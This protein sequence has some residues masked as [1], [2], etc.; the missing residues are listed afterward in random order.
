MRVEARSI[1]RRR[2]SFIGT[3]LASRVPSPAHPP[4][5]R[6]QSGHVRSVARALRATIVT[7]SSAPG[8]TTG[9]RRLHP[10][11]P[12]SSPRRVA[13]ALRRDVRSCSTSRVQRMGFRPTRRARADLLALRDATAGRVGQKRRWR[14]VDERRSGPST[15]PAARCRDRLSSAALRASGPAQDHRRQAVADR[16]VR[17]SEMAVSYPHGHR[18]PGAAIHNQAVQ[19]MGPMG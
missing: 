9:S 2:T 5:S 18:R 6:R 4:H 7:R 8:A 12:P 17:L 3:H 11:L 15:H 14:S 1:R 13:R 16:Q 10:F 19:R